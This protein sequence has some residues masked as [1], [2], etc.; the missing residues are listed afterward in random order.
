M[1]GSG[2]GGNST[3]AQFKPPDY[4]LQAW[5]DIVNNA[6]AITQQPY[7][8]YN[9]MEIAPINDSQVQGMQYMANLAGNM[10]PD[11]ATARAQNQLTAAGAFENPYSTIQT[12]NAM[13]P[14]QFAQGA[15]QIEVNR[16]RDGQNPYQGFSPEYQSF[17]QGAL[18]DVVGAYQRGTAAQTDSAFNRVG[19]FHGGGHDAQISANENNLARNLGR[20]SS[21]MD[22]EQWGR[23]AGLAE[24]NMN[25]NSQLEEGAINRVNETRMQDYA[26]NSGVAEAALNR[27]FQAQT[28]DLNRGSQYWDSERN[29]QVGALDQSIRGHQSD[30]NDGKTL[31][32]IG[33]MQRQYQQDMLNQQKNNFNQ[34][35]NYPFDMI[36]KYSNLIARASGNYG[37]QTSQ[38]QQNYQANPFAAMAGAGLLGA[39]MYNGMGG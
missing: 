18:D 12:E 20:T 28:N 37:S 39:G 30:L 35:Q 25:R 26:R 21:D 24:S 31:L 27:S 11:M 15:P 5:T 8:Q 6:T 10:A 19:A 36:D 1:G 32:G 22:F 17:K 16:Y 3:V 33:D 14:W 34:W 23:S 13:N 38:T 7:Q 9:G 29:R 2:G 4:A